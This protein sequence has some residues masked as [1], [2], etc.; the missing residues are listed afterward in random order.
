MITQSEARDLYQY[1]RGILEGRM[2]GSKPDAIRRAVDAANNTGDVPLGTKYG[3][4]AEYR[5]VS[6]ARQHRFARYQVDEDLIQDTLMRLVERLNSQL[7]RV[8]LRA[9]AKT[10]LRNVAVDKARKGVQTRRHIARYAE[11]VYGLSASSC[12]REVELTNLLEVEL[13]EMERT[14]VD[15]LMS[16]EQVFAR[17]KK[18]LREKFSAMGVSA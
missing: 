18:Q 5:N 4:A 8:E 7:P 13:T 15:R 3:H 14:R 6:K 11:T 12:E 16:G 2:R 9:Y 10:T 17:A 1:L